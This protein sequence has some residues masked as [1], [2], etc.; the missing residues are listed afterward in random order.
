MDHVQASD[1]PTL[2]VL[3][4][5]TS[6]SISLSLSLS[7]TRHVCCNWPHGVVQDGGVLRIVTIDVRRVKFVPDKNSDLEKNLQDLA[8][9]CN[10]LVLWL[11]CDREGENISMEVQSV[12]LKV[13]PA[14]RVSRARFSSLTPGEINKAV[15][16]LTVV[17]VNAADAVDARSEIDLRAGAAFSRLQTVHI[18]TNFQNLNDQVVSYGPCQFPTLGFVVKRFLEI[19][20]TSQNPTGQSIANTSD[21]ITYPFAIC[22]N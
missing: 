2:A 21:G 5:T 20:A 6:H 22:H 19:D 4:E 10:W 11:D 12:C 9:R 13:N 16:T 14:M 1:R 17:D 3:T 15:R 7:L 18:T 8:R